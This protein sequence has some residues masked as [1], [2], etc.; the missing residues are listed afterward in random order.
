MCG[1]MMR[2]TH[3][4]TTDVVVTPPEVLKRVFGKKK[5]VF[6]KKKNTTICTNKTLS[7]VKTS[8]GRE[9]NAS[10]AS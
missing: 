10:W 3:G 5:C 9:K 1:R 4:V 6:A 7:N 8:Q 2:V